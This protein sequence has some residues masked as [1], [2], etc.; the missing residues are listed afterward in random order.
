MSMKLGAATSQPST[1]TFPTLES[2]RPRSP[3]PGANDPWAVEPVA[4][5]QP[6]NVQNDEVLGRDGFGTAEDLRDDTG[7]QSYEEQVQDVQQVQSIPQQQLQQQQPP[8]NF[9]G[10]PLK[11]PLEPLDTITM[12]IAPEK[13]GVVFKHVNYIVESAMLKSSVLRRYSDFVWLHDEYLVKKFP[14]RILTEVGCLLLF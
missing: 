9:S 14:F 11:L 4:E 7:E 12:K 13:G 2:Y 1:T 6:I 3:S 10:Y 5:I 8:I